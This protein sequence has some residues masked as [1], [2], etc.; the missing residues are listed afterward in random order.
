MYKEF[1]ASKE[2]EFGDLKNNLHFDMLFA[3]DDIAGE[4]FVFKRYINDEYSMD[5]YENIY[6]NFK[7]ITYGKERFESDELMTRMQEYKDLKISVF[8]KET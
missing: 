5:E 3:Y 4:L 7:L 1:Q 2:I 6:D 8:V